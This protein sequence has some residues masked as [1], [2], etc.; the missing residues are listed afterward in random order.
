AA[1]TVQVG[2]QTVEVMANDDGRY[3]AEVASADPAA[4]V[5]VTGASPDG[6]VR[7]VSLVGALSGV[8]ALAGTDTTA[9][10]AAVLPALNAT[11]WTSAEAAL[12]VRAL[13]GTLPASAADMAT[14]DGA[15]R[16]QD[17]QSLAIAVNLVADQDAPLPDGVSDSFAL[18]L[19]GTATQAFVR[20][21]AVARPDAFAAA[22]QAVIDTAPVPAGEPWAITATRVLTYSDGGNPVSYVDLTLELEPDGTATSHEAGQRHAARWTA[23]GAVLQVTLTAPIEQP[24]FPCYD[25]PITGTCMQYAAVWRTLGYRLQAVAGGSTTKLPVLLATR[26]EHVWLEGPLAGQAIT[27]D[28]GGPGFLASVFDLAGRTGV[29][30]DELVAGARLAGVASEPVDPA[31][32]DSRDDILRITGQGTATFEISGQ[33]A[34]W[35]LDDGWVTVQTQG[36]PAR[37]YTRLERD[38]RTGLESWIAASVPGSASEPVVYSAEQELLFAEAG[39]VFTADT[40]ARRWRTEGYVLA[41]PEFYGL[42]PSYVFNPDGTASGTGI[43]SWRLA[44][45]GTLELVRVTQGVEYPRRWIPL[46]RVG[47]NLIALEIIDWGYIDPG[48]STRRINWQVDLGPAGG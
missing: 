33:P 17:L 15:V 41:N 34:T 37:R 3:V 20:A 30:A 2:D 38:P 18:L 45:D 12:R 14:S 31:Q 48:R 22:Q 9:V 29:A 35:S 7:L 16:P 27:T 43:Q 8:A 42:D 46:R 44:P 24:D 47:D 13:G 39:L 1:V 28:P 5:Q 40:A 36:M 32:G 11:H 6:R 10:D 19:D 4:W 23:D 26:F 25:D 21:Q